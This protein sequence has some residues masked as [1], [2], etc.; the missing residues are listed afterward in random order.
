M[1]EIG[2]QVNTAK[3][4]VTF[5]GERGSQQHRGALAHVQMFLTDFKEEDPSELTLLSSPLS[6][7]DLENAIETAKGNI[8][9]LCQQFLSFDDHTAMFL[10]TH[11]VSAPHLT[12]LLRSNEN[13][14]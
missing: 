1:L 9:R 4:E 7:G 3:F 13:K 11:Y 2:V 6:D 5:L 8:N 12:Y 10:S 14:N